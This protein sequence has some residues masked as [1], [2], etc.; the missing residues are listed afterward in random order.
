MLP[1]KAITTPMILFNTIGSALFAYLAA[2]LANTSVENT[3]N[4]IVIYLYDYNI[5]VSNF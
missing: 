2:T 5:K 3:Q 4:I 1:I